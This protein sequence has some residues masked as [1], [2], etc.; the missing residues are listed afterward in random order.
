ME[1]SSNIS[2]VA[3]TSEINLF[4]IGKIF[5]FLIFILR[6]KISLLFT[7]SSTAGVPIL[8]IS[9]VEKENLK[10]KE[11]IKILEEK[12]DE[13]KNISKIKELENIKKRLTEEILCPICLSI[14]KSK[15]IPVCENGH[16]TCLECIR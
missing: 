4:G 5:A 11:Q 15:K 3:A 16:T 6:N 2:K 12:L 9:E 7:G 8:R 13:N 1:D 14:P 10:L